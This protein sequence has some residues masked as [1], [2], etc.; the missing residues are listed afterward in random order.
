MTPRTASRSVIFCL[1]ASLAACRTVKQ[2]VGPREIPARSAE[3]IIERVMA[4]DVTDVRYYK[5]KA[6]VELKGPDG[7]KSFNAHIRSVHDSAAWVSVTPAL[8]I[9]VARAV[10]T[11][12]SLKLMDKMNDHYW[13]GD[14]TQAQRKFG[15]QPSLAL[16]QD[17][18]LGRPIGLDPQ[19][20]YKADREEGQY[21]LTS[22]ERRR[23]RRAAEDL[24]PEDTL[25]TDRDMPERRM[26][27]TMRRAIIKDAMVVRYWI[28]PDRFLVTRV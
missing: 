3:K 28:E 12:D 22:K 23:F 20:K 6:D 25:A 8:G 17:A 9:E 14:T 4:G 5:A 7:D 2:V 18:L 21:V 26:E 24:A 1:A 27:R 16:L 13:V 11:A 15:L 10:L 19:E